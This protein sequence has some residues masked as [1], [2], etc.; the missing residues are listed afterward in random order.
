MK[1]IIEFVKH[2]TPPKTLY[3][4]IGMENM[5]QDFIVKEKTIDRANERIKKYNKVIVR[6][7]IKLYFQCW[8]DWNELYHKPE[9]QR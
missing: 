8:I 7:C 6:N 3:G 2:N 5:F 9:Y 1:D 4:L